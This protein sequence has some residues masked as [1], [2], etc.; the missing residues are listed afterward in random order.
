MNTQL[1]LK[2]LSYFVSLAEAGHYRKAAERVG[3]SQPSL[4][5]QIANL[6]EALRLSLVERGRAGAVLTPEGREVL[7]R[8]QR[9]IADVTSLTEISEEMKTGLAGTIRLGSSPTL[10]PYLL[11]NVVRRLHEQYPTL[12]LVIRDGAPRELLDDLLAGRH[13]LILTQL[14][15]HSSDV[16]VTRLLREPLRLAVALDHPLAGKATVN[17][18]D[19]EGQNIL[20]LSS[21][22][23]LHSQIADLAREVGAKLRQDYEGTSLDAVRQMVAMNMGVT[24][25]PAL[26]VKSEISETD[27][28]VAILPYR[29]GLFTRSIGLIWRKSAGNHAGFNAFAQIIRSVAT[30]QFGKLVQL[31][32]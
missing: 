6:E 17:D 18:R 16:T 23:T 2:Q 5:L 27:G 9:I 30:D 19:L 26:Y 14:P 8:A 32:S 28:D 25:L 11:P 4:S 29:R 21:G 1:T 15:V 10:G 24:F 12:R 7:A 20:T 3:I 31:E 13:D 22:F